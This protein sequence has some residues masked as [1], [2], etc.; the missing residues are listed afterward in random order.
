MSEKTP[1]TVLW[2]LGVLGVILAAVIILPNS[3]CDDD[4]YG[5][6]EYYSAKHDSDDY[7][8]CDSSH[9]STGGIFSFRGGGPGFG[10]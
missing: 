9:G 7:D 10:K 2:V 8:N 6:D 4:R 3:D 5:D 1:K